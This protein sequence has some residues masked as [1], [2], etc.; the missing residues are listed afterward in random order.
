VKYLG[1][2]LLLSVLGA[3]ITWTAETVREFYAELVALRRAA[4]SSAESLKAIEISTRQLD[5]RE[6]MKAAK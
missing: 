1:V 5:E 2:V 4:E 3:A 6:W